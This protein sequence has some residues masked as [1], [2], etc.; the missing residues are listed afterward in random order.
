MCQ[1][2]NTVF[3]VQLIPMEMW[4]VLM[5]TRKILIKTKNI[6]GT[7]G[8]K[9][10]NNLFYRYRQGIYCSIC[11]LFSLF[12]PLLST[13]TYNYIKGPTHT[14]TWLMD[15]TKWIYIII[16]AALHDKSEK[17]LRSFTLLFWNDIAK[18]RAG[19]V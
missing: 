17:Y 9:N 1:Q 3:S 6:A 5:N 15:G 10:N 12:L 14:H 2:T 19:Y 11:C 4:D 13:S 18:N 7:E 8:T 16:S